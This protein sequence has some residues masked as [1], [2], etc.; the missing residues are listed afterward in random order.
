MKEAI[1]ISKLKLFYSKFTSNYII[2]C[3]AN[4]ETLSWILGHKSSRYEGIIYIYLFIF[5]NMKIC[6]LLIYLLYC[7]WILK[8]SFATRTPRRF[9]HKDSFS[10]F[11]KQYLLS[12]PCFNIVKPCIISF[13]SFFKLVV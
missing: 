12:L 8:H 10:F 11:I 1:Q 9:P 4:Y 6:I 3:N 7:L 13:L 2:E 5:I